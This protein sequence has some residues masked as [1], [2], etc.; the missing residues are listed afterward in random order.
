[1][2]ERLGW[3]WPVAHPPLWAVSM[4]TQIVFWGGEGACCSWSIEWTEMK[5]STEGCLTLEHWP[6]HFWRKHKSEFHSAHT[7]Q[8][9]IWAWKHA[10]SS[11]HWPHVLS[12]L[13]CFQC[14]GPRVCSWCAGIAIVLSYLPKEN[15]RLFQVLSQQPSMFVVTAACV[16]QFSSQRR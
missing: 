8:T 1:M 16:F 6:I 9:H 11:H 12:C 3:K 2:C 4:W 14:C 5:G 10:K 13:T 15:V 7:L